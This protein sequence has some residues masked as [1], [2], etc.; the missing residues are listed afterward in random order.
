MIIQLGGAKGVDTTVRPS[1]DAKPAH[2]ALEQPLGGYT[3]SEFRLR[4]VAIETSVSCFVL[5][6]FTVPGRTSKTVA[7]FA[8]DSVGRAS[9]WSS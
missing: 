9:G 7:Y 6:V 5:F 4:F 3:A 8:F 2:G 1:Q